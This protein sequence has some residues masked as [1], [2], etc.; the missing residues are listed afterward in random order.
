MGVAPGSV[1]VSD[2]V[3]FVKRSM[4]FVLAIAIA[5]L[6]LGALTPATSEPQLVQYYDGKVSQSFDRDELP[7]YNGVVY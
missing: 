7:L 1:Y 2:V 3:L 5:V 4:M 6:L